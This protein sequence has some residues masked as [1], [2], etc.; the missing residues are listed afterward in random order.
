MLNIDDIV[1]LLLGGSF[2]FAIIVIS[3]QVARVLAE[4]VA[5]LKDIRFVAQAA[6]SVVQEVAGDYK[7]AKGFVANLVN[8]T[9][10]PM[11]AMNLVRI[12]K[13]WQTKSKPK[14]DMAKSSSD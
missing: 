8:V 2:S 6:Q 7:A 9:K 10:A 3:W 14:N 4:I 5:G 13:K 11:N 1:K 12:F